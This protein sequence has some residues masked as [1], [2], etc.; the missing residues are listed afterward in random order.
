MKRYELTKQKYLSDEELAALN[1]ILMKY[2][3]ISP[4]DCTLIWLALYTGARAQEVLNIQ[5]EDVST[6]D[7]SVTIR[8]LKGSYS[9]EIPL[10]PWLFKRVLDLG[11]KSGPLFNI[12]YSRFQQIWYQY[13]PVR[14]KLHSLRHTFAIQLYKKSHD[15]RAIQFALGHTS[16]NTTM[17]YA[18]YQ[19]KTEELRRVI[20]G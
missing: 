13:R 9:R 8:G 4:R 7:M 14:K 6:Q 16:I 5:A 19:F 3:D 12:K 15:V 20:L 18:S 10:N 11:T 17:I 2:A 1:Q